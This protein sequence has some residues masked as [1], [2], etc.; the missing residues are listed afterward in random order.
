LYV[1]DAVLER[2]AQDL[3]HLPATLRPFIQ[4][5]GAVVRQRHLARHRHLA[6]ADQADIRDGV[7]GR[8]TRAGRDQRRT[9]AGEAGDAMEACRLNGFGQV[10]AGRMV[11][12]RR[13]SIDVPAPEGPS[14]RTLWAE[15]LRKLYL[16]FC[17]AESRHAGGQACTAGPGGSEEV[18][19]EPMP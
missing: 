1:C 3:E 11:V 19:P 14:R 9:V 6:P 17:I 15:R 4:D 8:A 13:A 18:M 2:L 7:V 5:E 12:S 10:I 16:R